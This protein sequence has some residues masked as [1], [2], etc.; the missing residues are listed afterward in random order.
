MKTYMIYS[1]KLK[2]YNCLGKLTL[3]IYTACTVYAFSKGRKTWMRVRPLCY[4]FTQFFYPVQ[5]FSILPKYK[6]FWYFFSF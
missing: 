6:S 3:R 4:L 5:F 2:A 1:Y